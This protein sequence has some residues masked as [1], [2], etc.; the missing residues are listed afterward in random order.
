[1]DPAEA[2]RN[3]GCLIPGLTAHDISA[4]DGGNTMD[5]H[6]HAVK[7]LG[8][9]ERLY[10]AI[11][12]FIVEFSKLEHELKMHVA[13]AIGLPDE[14][15]VA[16]MTQ[17]FA[18]LCTVAQTVLS[19]IVS[20]ADNLKAWISKC[21]SLNDDRVRVVHGLWIVGFDGEGHGLIHV[22]RQKLEYTGHFRDVD[23]LARKADLA[24]TLGEE[25]REVILDTPPINGGTS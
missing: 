23:D 9:G 16:I 22:P 2:Q 1:M 4:L 13:G 18:S 14:H 8:E 17:D 3:G 10:S 25:L 15:F 24:K 21:R 12:R 5:H 19:P 11:G 20:K 6:L 7:K